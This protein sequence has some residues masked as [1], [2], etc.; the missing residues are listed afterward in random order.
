M[1]PP[2]DRRK[3]IEPAG[4]VDPQISFLSLATPAGEPL[5]VLANYSL[6]YVGGVPAGELSADYFGAFAGGFDPKDGCPG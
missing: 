5:A 2:R 3:L 1:N 4:P 6:H